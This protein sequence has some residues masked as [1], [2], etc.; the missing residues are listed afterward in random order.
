MQASPGALLRFLSV[1]RPRLSRLSKR[2]SRS[3]AS[4]PESTP[5]LAR[6]L[7]GRISMTYT[8]VEGRSGKT[9]RLTKKSDRRVGYLIW[10]PPT[11]DL[12][13]L[14]LSAFQ[15]VNETDPLSYFAISGKLCCKRL[16][17]LTISPKPV[18]TSLTLSRYPRT[19]TQCVERSRASRWRPGECWILSP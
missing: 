19:P 13:I 5:R 8:R 16:A 7:R 1:G 4:R 10:L 9:E 17:C 14:A 3:S 12:Y 18:R 6:G 11:R 15:D 2:L